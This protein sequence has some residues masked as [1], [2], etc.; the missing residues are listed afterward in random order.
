MNGLTILEDLRRELADH[1]SEHL[2]A[3]VDDA[4]A[5]DITPW[6]AMSLMQKGI[7]RG[8]TAWALRGAATLLRDAPERLWRRLE[9]VRF[10][11]GHPLPRPNHPKGTLHG[12][13]GRGSGWP[14][15]S[16]QT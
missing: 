14:G 11:P 5:K 13:L 8:R 10:G 1:V 3:G 6:M 4:E 12:W 2:H 15:D 16:D 7:R 9:H